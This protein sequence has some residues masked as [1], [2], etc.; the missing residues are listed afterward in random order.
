MAEQTATAGVADYL[1]G[2]AFEETLDKVVALI[3]GAGMTLFA[4]IDHMAGARA[5]G[6]DMP[7]TVLLLYGH[8]R[9]GTPIM[10]ATPLAGLELPL[11]VLVRQDAEGRTRMS[12]HPIVPWLEAVGVP[13]GSASR[14]EPAQQ[15]LLRAI[16]Q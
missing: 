3:E 13:A 15:I 12:F 4:R 14:L 1:T 6:L 8:P 2:E 10:L 16:R 11:R 7:P 5:V 9:G